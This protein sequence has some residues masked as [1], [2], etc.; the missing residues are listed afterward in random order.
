MDKI[1]GPAITLS[2]LSIQL[3]SVSTCVPSPQ[4]K[5]AKLHG[6]VDMMSTQWAV[7]NL[8]SL[9]SLVGHLVHPSKVCPLGKAFRNNLFVVLSAMKARQ[10]RRFNLAARADLGWW[11][12]LLASW[13]GTSIQQFLIFRQPDFHLFPDVSGSWGCGAWFGSQW[14]QVPWPSHSVLSTPVLREL[15]AIGIACAVWGQDWSGRLVLCHS[16]NAAAVT[17]GNRLHAR[18]ALACHM[19]RCPAFFFSGSS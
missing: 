15:Y 6:L 11:Q 16:D 17:H 14:F 3:N 8:H 5:L 19:L 13:S 4:G 12:A 1:E 9:E 2:F 7:G 10:Y 18:D